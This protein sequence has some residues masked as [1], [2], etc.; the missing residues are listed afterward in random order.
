[1]TE[2]KATFKVVGAVT[3]ST[4]GDEPADPL[5]DVLHWVWSWRTQLRRLQTSTVEQGAGDTAI[6]RRRSS[7]RASFDE[8]MLA[9]VGWNLTRALDTAQGRLPEVTVSRHTRDAL[10][11]LRNLYEHWDQQR[12]SFGSKTVTKTRSG[13]E[14]S[15]L[16]PEGRPWSI[17]FTATEWYLGGVLAIGALTRQLDTIEN[18]ILA[19]QGGFQ[20]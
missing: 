2:V 6:D 16:F 9:V 5:E 15:T 12:L 3:R 19:I 17:A 14:F 7:S 4:V 10:R 8:H 1:M 20:P 11:L 18:E 13:A